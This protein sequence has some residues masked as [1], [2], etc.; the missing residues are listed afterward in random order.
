M[1]DVC[2]TS[3]TLENKHVKT[4][5]LSRGFLDFFF[6]WN[7]FFFLEPYLIKSWYT[8]SRL[9]RSYAPGYVQTSGFTY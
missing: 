7:F 9:R 8:S 6:F 4:S 1:L 2:G 5:S 3:M